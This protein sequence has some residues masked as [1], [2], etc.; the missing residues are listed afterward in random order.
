MIY[1]GD[2]KL[3]LNHNMKKDA[4]QILGVGAIQLAQ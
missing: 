2:I 4:E 3:D 1:L